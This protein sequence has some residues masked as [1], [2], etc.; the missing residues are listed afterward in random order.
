MNKTRGASDH[1][2]VGIIIALKDI[3]CGGQNVIKRVWKDF[4][5]N[6]CLNS[7]RGMDCNEVLRE[8]DVN[9]ANS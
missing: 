9:L 4:D 6:R 2:V 5:L 8:N 7:F 3:K 1:S